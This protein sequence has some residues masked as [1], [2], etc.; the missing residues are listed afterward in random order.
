M[1]GMDKKRHISGLIQ[2]SYFYNDSKALFIMTRVLIVIPARYQSSRLP[3]KLLKM[4]SNRTILQHVYDN[5][6]QAE[7]VSKVLVATDHEIIFDHCKE[8]NMDVI[9]TSKHHLSGTDRVAEATRLLNGNFDLIINVQGDEPMISSN[10]I[11]TLVNLM[12]SAIAPIGTLYVEEDYTE[13]N[14]P[15]EVKLVSNAEHK[16]MYF[17]RSNIPFNRD[18][19]PKIKLKKHI[20]IYAFHAETLQELTDLLP[21]NLEQTEMLEQL[22]WLENNYE[23]CA[24]A[25]DYKGFGID[26]QDDL[27]RARSIMSINS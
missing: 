8:H 2:I 18:K 13:I 1:F 21:T 12:A 15:N 6:L 26:T 5:C 10:E 14:N 3:A 22:R 23:I 20:G 17:S 19:T 9:M 7:V 24:T 16:V 27:E 4:I 25:V 11:I